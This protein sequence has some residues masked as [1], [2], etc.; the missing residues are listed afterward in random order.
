MVKFYET[1][2]FKKL[3]REWYLKDYE[4]GG[5]DIETAGEEGPLR[6]DAADNFEVFSPSAEILDQCTEESNDVRDAV[7]SIG[8]RARE[9]LDNPD[10]WEDLPP[11]A[12]RWWGLV[13]L[14]GWSDYRAR[15]HLGVNQ[16]VSDK[17]R[18]TILERL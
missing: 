3:Q 15:E 4:A 9:L 11:E 8:D 14:A 12:R 13:V 1:P 10:V 16:W 7:Y 6:N 5:Q 2:E 17:W 18:K